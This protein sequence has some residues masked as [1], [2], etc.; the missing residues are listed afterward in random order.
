MSP[1][2]QGLLKNPKGAA[3]EL[4]F[5]G[6]DS[7]AGEAGE[8]VPE[9][10]EPVFCSAAAEQDFNAP[11]GFPVE[12]RVQEDLA[13]VAVVRGAVGVICEELRDIPF[14][15]DQDEQADH[16]EEAKR[17]DVHDQTEEP[18]SLER[19]RQKINRES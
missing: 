7:D 8:S 3:L 5:S 10:A 15:E 14:Y 1:R 4:F 18:E 9:A 17:C 19:D 11:F 12:H 2:W 16:W 13:A 6:V